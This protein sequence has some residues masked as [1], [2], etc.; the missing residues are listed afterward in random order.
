MKSPKQTQ[1]SIVNCSLTQEQRLFNGE[2]IFIEKCRGVEERNLEVKN[3]A[4]DLIYTIYTD[5]SFSSTVIIK[6]LSTKSD[7]FPFIFLYHLTSTLGIPVCLK[8]QERRKFSLQ[9]H[10]QNALDQT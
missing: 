7:F 5:C 3:C 6:M 10:H 8:I 2:K 4:S 9:I 1:T